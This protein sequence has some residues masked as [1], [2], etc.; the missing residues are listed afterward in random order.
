MKQM[1]FFTI[2][3][4]FG[5]ELLL[6]TRKDYRPITSQKPIHL[7]MRSQ[8]VLKHGS[9]KK[10]EA[11]TRDLIHTFAETYNIKIYRLA[12]CSNHL[13][14]V[15]RYQDK[16]EFQNFL[17]VISG[18]I[19]QKIT[20]EKGFW[21]HRPFTRVLEWGRDFERVLNYTEQNILETDGLIDYKSR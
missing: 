13:H 2:P 7:V 9:F 15:L 21:L 4:S 14:F 10:H 18:Q 6:N 3:K 8:V 1:T 11:L 16:K 12:V 19:A 17:R 5:G 20:N